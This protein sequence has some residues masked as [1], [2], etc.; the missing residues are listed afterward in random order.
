MKALVLI[1]GTVTYFYN[2]TGRRLAEALRNLGWTVDLHTLKTA[3]DQDYDY[4]FLMNTTDLVLSCATPYDAIHRLARVR[5]RCRCLALVLLEPVE[6]NWFAHA[7]DLGKTAQIDLLLDGGLYSQ[8]DR[9]AADARPVYR[10]FF[11]GLTAAE[12][13]SIPYQVAHAARPI[14]WV[15]VGHATTTRAK[16]VK[17]L[18]EEVDPGGFVYL[19]RLEAVTED[20]PHLNEQQFM[21]A[22]RHAR[23]QVWCSHHQGFY[24]EGERFRM[25][26]LAGALP[27]K[28]LLHPLPDRN[29]W[30][31]AYLLLD[32]DD[33]PAAMRALDP[34]AL[35][36]RFVADFCALPSLEVGLETALAGAGQTVGGLR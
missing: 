16:L 10:F 6:T 27:L 3:P 4:V 7:Y 26:L 18:M 20:G 28:I 25:S 5:A 29:R 8:A 33:F 34:A 32:K 19:S 36:N 22:L 17:R 31:F 11:N 15:M 35:W 21:A 9:V 12:R 24:L 23:Y 30:P 2:L 1:S 14:P 13:A